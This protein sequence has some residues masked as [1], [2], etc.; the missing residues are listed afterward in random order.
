M[1][2]ALYNPANRVALQSGR[3]GSHFLD[4]AFGAKNGT[5]PLHPGA[6]RYFTEAGV[7]KPAQKAALPIKPAARKS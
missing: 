2:K 3:L 1:L 4:P 5:V 6:V 7:L